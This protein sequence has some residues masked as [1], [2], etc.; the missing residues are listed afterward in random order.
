MGVI[1]PQQSEDYSKEDFLKKKRG[2]GTKRVAGTK[3]F[4]N[5]KCRFSNLLAPE[6]VGRD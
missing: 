6:E 5:Q 4:R 1:T 2:L 3:D